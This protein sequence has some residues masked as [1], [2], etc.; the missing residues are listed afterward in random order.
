MHG[1][2]NNLKNNKKEDLLISCGN[3]GNCEKQYRLI[4]R[5]IAEI[6]KT[7]FKTIWVEPSLY[8]SSLPKFMKPATYSSDMYSKVLLAICRPGIGTITECIQHEIF[9]LLFY[10]N[11]Y[12]MKY[13]DKRISELKIGFS[14]KNIIEILNKLSYF[15]NNQHKLVNKFSNKELPGISGAK[16][17]FPPAHF[18]IG[19]QTLFCIQSNFI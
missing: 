1:I 3:G 14:C 12:E 11:N 2:K 5:K 9:T 15:E 4:V 16:D 8:E 10:E 17:V 19:L 18:K 6:N 13:I 7:K